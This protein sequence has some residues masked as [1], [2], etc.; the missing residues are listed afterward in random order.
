MDGEEDTEDKEQDFFQDID[1]DGNIITPFR[2]MLLLWHRQKHSIQ[3]AWK[4]RT[5]VLNLR[6]LPGSLD[7]LPAG[8]LA[9]STLKVLL[10]KLRN[11]WRMLIKVF[12]SSLKRMTM[13]NV[14]QN[15]S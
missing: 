9:S 7:A 2:V 5:T 6:F 15:G 12:A 4:A 10:I 8:T 3:L 11:A 1:I 14:G 13:T